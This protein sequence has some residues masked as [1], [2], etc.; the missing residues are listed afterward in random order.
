MFARYS[1][2]SPRGISA[3]LTLAA[4]SAGPTQCVPPLPTPEIDDN[5]EIGAPTLQDADGDGTPESS[6][7]RILGPGHDAED[8][9][10]RRVEYGT[11]VA[12]S[13][14]KLLVGAPDQ[15]V[16]ADFDGVVYAYQRVDG[17]WI[18]L[19]V[20]V[21]SDDAGVSR[22]FGRSLSMWNDVAIVGAPHD[23]PGSAYVFRFSEGAWHEEAKLIA[24][25]GQLGDYFGTSVSIFQNLA[26]VGAPQSDDGGENRGAAY[27]F[28]LTAGSWTQDHKF[29]NTGT[30][31]DHDQFGTSVAQ[32][33]NLVIVGENSPSGGAYIHRFTNGAW[34]HE[35]TLSGDADAEV[36]EGFGRS[37]AIGDGRAVVGSP[38]D[39]ASG[40]DSG[41]AYAYR[42]QGYGVWTEE[43]ELVPADGF[44]GARFGWSVALYGNTAVIGAP[45][46]S[47]PEFRT[48]AVYVYSHTA[49]GIW[50][51]SAAYAPPGVTDRDNVGHSISIAAGTIVAG[52]PGLSEDNFLA[53][54]SAYII[55]VW[56]PFN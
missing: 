50:S 11:A 47:V 34:R 10:L 16:S 14:D 9:I 40:L 3:L 2:L 18:K 44:G 54:E 21:P 49:N 36:N 8:P 26:V 4:L 53:E 7:V 38:F 29:T 1:P 22:R 28:R 13:G 27:V 6:W 5:T 56:A 33:N 24:D 51:G 25:G 30:A 20:V 39:G 15:S 42:H 45:Q 23:G 19:P 48:G 41:K 12:V 46:A 31:F 35:A 32:Y 37:V 52:A 17:Q 55:D 43:A